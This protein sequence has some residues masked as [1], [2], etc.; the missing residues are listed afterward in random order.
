MSVCVEMTTM[1]PV[2]KKKEHREVACDKREKEE[3]R[4]VACDRKNGSAEENDN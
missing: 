1:T 4:E 3:N 2:R